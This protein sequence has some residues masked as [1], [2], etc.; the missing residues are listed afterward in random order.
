[1]PAGLY[2][3][4]IGNPE[5]LAVGLDTLQPATWQFRFCQAQKSEVRQIA[6]DRLEPSVLRENLADSSFRKLIGVEGQHRD[7]L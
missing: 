2:S 3:S 5:S 4:H 7:V 1:M 6:E